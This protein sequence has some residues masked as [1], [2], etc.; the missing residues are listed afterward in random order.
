L[1]KKITF[2]SHE[3]SIKY[4]NYAYGIQF[5]L[6]GNM[7]NICNGKASWLYGVI[8]TISLLFGIN[9]NVLAWRAGGGGW[10]GGGGGWHGG[11]GGWHGGYGGWHG[12]YGGWH[13]GYGGWHGGYGGYGY[14]G[15]WGYG[16]AALTGGLMGAAIV[17]SYHCQ[18]VT[19]Y[20][21]GYP[22]RYKEC[23]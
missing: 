13:G 16:A 11:Y 7:M 3:S 1:S 22:I 6:K 4:Y 10:H 12:G 14:G 21:N 15:G 2:I 23:Y 5:Y 9:T 8:F 18:W 19:G 17:N 20:R